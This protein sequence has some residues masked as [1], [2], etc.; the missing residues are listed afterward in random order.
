[1]EPDGI[2]DKLYDTEFILDCF[3]REDRK[4]LQKEIDNTKASKATYEEFSVQV[5]E[6]Y[7]AKVMQHA[8]KNATHPKHPLYRCKYPA[9]L[10][11]GIEDL[12]QSVAKPLLPPGASIWRN[13]KQGGWHGHLPPHKRLGE[14]WSA[15]GHNSRQAMMH[16]MARLWKLFIFDH[17]L[18]KEDCP[19]KGIRDLM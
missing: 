12:P 2:D 1:M 9:D 5:R 19:I 17:G 10:P 16:T 13:N 11:P 6:Y 7:K 15:H 18:T 8:G 14:P 3:D 4:E